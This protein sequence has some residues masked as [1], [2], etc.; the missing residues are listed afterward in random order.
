MKPLCGLLLVLVVSSSSNGANLVRKKRFFSTL[1]PSEE[2]KSDVQ[3]GIIYSQL[4]PEY[5]SLLPGVNDHKMIQRR[6]GQQPT[7]FVHPTRMVILLPPHQQQVPKTAQP[8]KVSSPVN[9][10]DVTMTQPYQQGPR[11]VMKPVTQ[12]AKLTP[13]IQLKTK[14][15][16]LPDIHKTHRFIPIKSMSNVSQ[17]PLIQPFNKHQ[18]LPIKRSF[19]T[20]SDVKSNLSVKT[21][22]IND[23]YHTKEFQDLLVSLKISVDVSKLPPIS[24]VMDIFGTESGEELLEKIRSVTPEDMEMIKSYLIDNN[25]DDEFYDH[26][27]DIVAGEIK[28]VGNVDVKQ[29]QPAYTAGLNLPPYQFPEEAGNL[30]IYTLTRA[31][32]TGTLTGGERSWWRPSTWFT[33]APSTRIDSLQKDAE[34]AKKIVPKPATAY[35]GINYIGNFLTPTSS[36]SVPIIPISN[37]PRRNFQPLRFTHQSI[38]ED[39][40]TLP[41]IRMSENQYQDMIKK[42]RPSP[43]NIQHSQTVHSE[44]KVQTQGQIA[45]ATSVPQD[46]FQ[47]PINVQSVSTGISQH[48]LP[49]PST[50]TQFDEPIPEKPETFLE[51]PN[52][53]PNLQNRRNFISVSEP[54]RSA[55][56]DFVA[57]GKI[58]KVSPEEVLKKSRSLAETLI[59]GWFI[60]SSYLFS[61]IIS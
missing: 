39:T 21:A 5:L 32:T 42:I 53:T 54:Q 7:R 49:L 34:I 52:E 50:Y 61:L 10:K 25:V 18:Q 38:I 2:V 58:H 29:S 16:A 31:T 24:D 57:T 26:D 46:K 6:N 15:Q 12:N 27:S 9:N 55:P 36:D 3:N 45:D 17:K 33:S 56:Y 19:D 43:I 30:P 13:S 48:S 20:T 1:W 11:I 40:K 35:E 23:F 37:G 4:P 14:E 28:V 51:L 60:L 47:A 22:D 59:E 44:K 8:P 41:V